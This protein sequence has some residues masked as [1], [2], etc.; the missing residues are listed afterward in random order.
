M[1]GKREP[2]EKQNKNFDEVKDSYVKQLKDKRLRSAR[3]NKTA[4]LANKYGITIDHKVLQSIK[5]KNL[6]MLV[7][8]NFGFGGSGL[9]MPIVPP[10]FEWVEKWQNSKQD[11]P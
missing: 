6:S 7:F 11:L 4:E 1:I 2:E 9:A 10:F 5:V 8:K 3:I